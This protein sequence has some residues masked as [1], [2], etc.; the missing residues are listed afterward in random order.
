VVIA[1]IG[2]LAGMLLPALGRAKTNAQKQVCRAEENGIVAAIAQYNAD[3]TRLPASSPAIAAAGGEAATGANSNDF[4]FGTVTNGGGVWSSTLVTGLPQIQTVGETAY[5]NFNSEVISILRDDLLYPESSNGI[6][7]IYNPKKTGYLN[8]SKVTTDAVSPG[9]GTN[10]VFLDPWGCPYIITLDLNYDGK[11]FDAALNQMYQSPP[12][13]ANPVPPTPAPLL[14]NGEAVVWSLG[15]YW[16]TVNLNQ[17][18]NS[19]VNHQTIV[20]SFQ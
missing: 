14:I 17:P 9:I 15:P 3:Y 2:I 7:H 11:C 10:D 16:K 12:P 8:A 1:I 5:Q 4:T 6:S 20:G 19:G 13:N 18:L